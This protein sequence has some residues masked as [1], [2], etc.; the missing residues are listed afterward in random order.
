MEDDP[1]DHLDVVVAHL[2]LSPGDLADDG[3]GLGQDVVETSAVFEAGDE[4]G[5]LGLEFVVAQT[6][7]LVFPLADALN[8][9]GQLL[10]F[11][12]VGIAQERAGALLRPIEQTHRMQSHQLSAR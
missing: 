7:D 1:A 5:G 6:A 4:L 3:E 9:A 12:R 11:T 10:D 2:D 8:C